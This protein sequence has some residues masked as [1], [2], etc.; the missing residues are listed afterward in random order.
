LLGS[1]AS[2]HHGPHLTP[3]AALLQH[4]FEEEP[5][6]VLTA[7]LAT[8]EVTAIN[9]AMADWLGVTADESTLNLFS[10][11]VWHVL[12]ENA[13]GFEALMAAGG[14]AHA[15]VSAAGG[16]AS[17]SLTQ[18]GATGTVPPL[19]LLQTVDSRP[20]CARHSSIA[21][22]TGSRRWL[23]RRDIWRTTSMIC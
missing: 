17:V 8:G 3:D 14:V 15:E 13:G 6:G 5:V 10:L 1:S 23:G 18:I 11:A 2:L 22:M 7:D 20:H 9:R 19:W 16:P 12:V 21:A 4:I